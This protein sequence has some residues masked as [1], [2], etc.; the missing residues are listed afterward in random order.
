MKGLALGGVWLIGLAAACSDEFEP[1]E[2]E[3]E[4]PTGCA[5]WCQ[6]A[7]ECTG[8]TQ[9]GCEAQCA[10]QFPNEGSCGD[11]AAAVVTCFEANWDATCEQ[12]PACIEQVKAFASCSGLGCTADNGICGED[13]ANDLAC[14]CGG[15]CGSP[16]QFQANCQLEGNNVSCACFLSGEIAPAGA[17][18]TIE[19]TCSGPQDGEG[20]FCQDRWGC[21]RAK[22][23]QNP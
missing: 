3:P 2:P 19:T 15:G 21:C 18:G 5:A 9:D 1:A 7:S 20:D 23:L 17:I 14:R 11:E 4:L 22:L 6:K 8:V 16:W 10:A 13:A 12:P